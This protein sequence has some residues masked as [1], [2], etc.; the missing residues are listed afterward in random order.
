MDSV[1]HE[2]VSHYL[3]QNLVEGA[4]A[5][6]ADIE[7]RMEGRIRRGNPFLRL[8][9]IAMLDE[10]GLPRQLFHSDEDITV[11]ITFECLQPVQHAFIVLHVVDE[12]AVPVV[13]S[14]NVDDPGAAEHFFRFYTATCILPKNTFGG[15]SFF[16][17]VHLAYP[18]TEHV[19]VNKVLEFKVVFK[20]Y[21]NV[22]G[23]TYEVFIRPQLT[24]TMQ[25]G[26][27]KELMK[28]K[29]DE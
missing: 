4:V 2:V 1:T 15:R 28:Q 11:S 12:N 14:H 16:L 27:R 5:S 23:D 22:Y 8:C 18:K 21:N 17:T 10:S 3:D 26:H 25:T 7:Q 13:E 20:G 6:R 24:W 9:E 29:V 19:F